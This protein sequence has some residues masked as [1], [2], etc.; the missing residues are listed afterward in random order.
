MCNLFYLILVYDSFLTANREKT[1]VLLP[2]INLPVYK[3]VVTFG[4][5]CVASGNSLSL[6]EAVLVIVAGRSKSASHVGSVIAGVN[7]PL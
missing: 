4:A 1:Y 7:Q 2:V 6:R 3:N 5:I